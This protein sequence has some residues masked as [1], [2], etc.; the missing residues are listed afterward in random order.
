MCSNCEKRKKDGFIWCDV[1]GEKVGG[2]EIIRVKPLTKT[3]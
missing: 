1:C 2:K 3:R